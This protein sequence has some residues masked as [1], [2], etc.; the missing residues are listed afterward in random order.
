MSGSR[1][2]SLWLS[3]LSVLLVAG[4]LYWLTLQAQAIENEVPVVTDDA[5]A[6]LMDFIP[7]QLAAEPG[8]VVGQEGVLRDIGVA[9]RLGRGVI[10]VDLDG[11]ATYPILLSSDLIQR[12]TQIIRGDRVTAY[13]RAYTLNDSIRAVWVRQ[14]AVDAANETAIPMSTSFVLADSIT[15]N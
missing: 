12:G 7:A 14:S 10:T 2:A 3:I 13:G 8:S 1:G 5:P 15:S 4:F 9:A 6:E 11:T